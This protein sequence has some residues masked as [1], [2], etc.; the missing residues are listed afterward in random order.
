[1]KKRIFS[2]LLAVAMLSSMF[3]MFAFSSSAEDL[4]ENTVLE[5]SDPEYA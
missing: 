4:T 5:P 2:L 3:T 1:M